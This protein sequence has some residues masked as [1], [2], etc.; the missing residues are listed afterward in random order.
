MPGSLETA[1]L[2]LRICGS[3]CVYEEEESSIHFV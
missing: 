1:A 3:G 2:M